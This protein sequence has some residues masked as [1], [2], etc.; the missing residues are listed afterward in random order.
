MQPLTDPQMGGADATTGLDRPGRRVLG[1][2]HVD[3][4]DMWATVLGDR[5]FDDR[6]D[7]V[8]PA[9]LAAV[10]GRRRATADAARAIDPAALSPSQRVTRQMLIDEADGPGAR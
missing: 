9:G 6:L 8:S 5:R 3:E 7:E 4:P 1:R 10:A 2:C